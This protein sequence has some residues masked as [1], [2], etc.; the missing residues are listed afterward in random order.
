MALEEPQTINRFALWSLLATG[1]LLFPVS[2]VFAVVGLVQIVR[3]RGKQSGLVFAA[4]ALVVSG[5]LAPGAVWVALYGKPRAF[6]ACYHTQET[7]MGVLRLVSYLEER[8]HE[9]T[10]RYGSLDDIGF[11]AKVSTRPY[12]YAVER[13]DDKRFL[14]TARGS[15]FMEGDLLT[16]DESKQVHR[17][18][19]RCQ[20][21]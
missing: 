12:I 6:D 11:R 21:P 3:S 19:S 5:L 8:H 10:G 15:D 18:L 9:R 13:H 20:G 16:V 4:L 2:L 1:L 17:V 7:A 14:A